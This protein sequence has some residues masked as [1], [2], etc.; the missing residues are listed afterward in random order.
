MIEVIVFFGTLQG[1]YSTTIEL[2][3][4]VAPFWEVQKPSF[5][6]DSTDVSCISVMEGNVC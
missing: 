3:V 4:D 5:D 2:C 1:Q 6:K